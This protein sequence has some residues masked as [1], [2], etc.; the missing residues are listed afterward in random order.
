M[1]GA[2]LRGRVNE[3]K[4]HIEDVVATLM[5]KAGL[6]NEQSKELPYPILDCSSSFLGLGYTKP[7]LPAIDSAL[8]LDTDYK[9]KPV[10]S[11][12][13]DIKSNRGQPKVMGTDRWINL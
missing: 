6:S 10:L 8:K 5:G 4:G 11:R 2:A 12:K 13:P 1:A 9:S 7:F 3:D